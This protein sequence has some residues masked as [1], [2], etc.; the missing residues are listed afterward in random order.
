MPFF[1]K[2]IAIKK[3]LILGVFN[4]FL[5]KDPQTDGDME[6]EPPMY[7]CTMLSRIPF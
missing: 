6:Q 7:K 2:K 1:L 5:A 3:Q 4:V